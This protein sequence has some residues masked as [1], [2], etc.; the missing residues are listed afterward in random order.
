MVGSLL[1]MMAYSK[2]PRTTFALAHPVKALH[3]KKLGFDM[4]HAYAPRVAA[5]GVAA[6]A[7]PIGFALG[8]LNGHR[9]PGHM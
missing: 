9:T 2:A 6:L 3:W 5:L 4:R 7:I 8:R 1:K